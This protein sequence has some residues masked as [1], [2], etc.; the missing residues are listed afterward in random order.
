MI[1]VLSDN[2]IGLK[3]ACADGNL[4]LC[5]GYKSVQRGS[6]LENNIFSK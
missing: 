4:M 2:K 1:A 5:F 6:I 3:V